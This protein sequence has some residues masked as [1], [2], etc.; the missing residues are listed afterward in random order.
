MTIKVREWNKGKKMGFEVDISIYLPGRHAV[1]AAC[2][3]AG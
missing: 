1:P 2:Q 3:S